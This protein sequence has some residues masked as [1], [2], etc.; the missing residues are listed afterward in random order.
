MC[1]VAAALAPERAAAVSA[2]A[3][4]CDRMTARGP[5][6]HGIESFDHPGGFAVLGSRRL[7]IVDPSPAGHQ[8]MLDPERG[9]A[10]TY[11]GMLY[12]FRELRR[13]LEAAGERFCSGCDTEVVL[14]AYATWG[15]VCVE[16]MHGMFAFAVWDPAAAAL[17][18][19]R[20]RLGIKPL[21]F[22]EV[23]GGVYVSS[24]V[25]AL[26]GAFPALRELDP[27]AVASF[28][29][30]GAVA[31]P[32]TPFAQICALPA[33]HTAVVDRTGV[34]TSRYWS[35]AEIAQQGE[36]SSESDPEAMLGAS[37]R[38]AVATHLV[39][40]VP[41]GV[42]L[43]GGL[44]SSVLAALAAQEEVHIRTVSVV[45]DDRS[46]SEDR[47]SQL[48]ARHI[49][50]EHVRL[51]LGAAELRD[52]LPD[53]FAAMDQPSFD[54]VNT[55]AVSRAAAASGLTVALSGL[56]ADELFDGYGYHARLERLELLKRLPAP[57]G[58]A[59]AAVAGRLGAR[60]RETKLS[61]WLTADYPPGSG[62]GLLRGLF[63]PAEVAALSGVSGT[64]GDRAAGRPLIVAEL[65][66]YL[67]NVLLRDTDCMSMANSLEVRVPYLDD[68]VVD[69]C[70]RLPAKLRR[71]KRIL[72]R[73]ANGL[74][75][76]EVAQRP[77]HGFLLPL[78]EWM[79]AEYADEMRDVLHSLPPAVAEIVDPAGVAEAWKAY[80]Q[81]RSGWLRPWALYSLA[82]WT[83]SLA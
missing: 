14:R 72:A 82:K 54:G 17:F 58:R 56:G 4:M 57:F 30:S 38:E 9:Y 21:Y 80:N 16:R 20:D 52:W 59:A 24:Q 69:W 75:P 34:R 19:A 83:E 79:R 11:N 60:R 26:V 68:A 66:H 61:A 36:L 71:D 55:Y 2:V 44:D 12:N 40:D 28:L 3:T 35:A 46:L 42:F 43:S 6:D 65:D 78:D 27:A 18:L 47:Y 70:L 8:P 39:S 29:S 31:E 67:R 49:G 76:S 15:P 5:D 64:N 45:F 77:K 22:A 51:E 10:V 33:G 23:N 25:K 48:V 1:G 63:V 7:A 81:G 62:Y 53:A 37:L 13:E 50:S 32:L 74:I 41:L 73:V